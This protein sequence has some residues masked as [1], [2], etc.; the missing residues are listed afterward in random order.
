M[1]S[2]RKLKIIILQILFVYTLIL[3]PSHILFV[4]RLF[5]HNF[6]F[7]KGNPKSNYPAYSDNQFSDEIYKELFLMARKQKYSG[8]KSFL[9][10][11]PVAQKL[12]H[13]NVGGEYNTRF[14]IGENLNNSLW[15]FGGSTMWG[16][17][18]YDEAT[19]PSLYYKITGKEVF[20]FAEIAWNSRQS[21][22]QMISLFGD[23]NKPN[24]IIFFDGVNDIYHG[25]RI[26]NKN[27]PVHSREK[28]IASLINTQ[29][30][31]LLK[32]VIEPYQ[33]IYNKLFANQSISSS[34]DCNTN[35]RKSEKIAEHLVNNWYSAYLISRQSNI[36]F[37]AVLQPTIYTSGSN[38]EY[39]SE[40]SKINVENMKSNFDAVYP[41]IKNK[42]ELKCKYD[43]SFCD[44]FIDA[45]KFINKNDRLFLDECHLNKKGNE[46]II[47]KLISH[48][49]LI[50][51][52]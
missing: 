49:N 37:Y 28:L 51:F 44:S 36:K 33:L 18:T 2:F 42:I 21:L 50:E 52:Q 29:D 32:S 5:N 7:Y 25:C 45:T 13:I 43:Q 23:G 31:F 4:Y 48:I 35:L 10:W 16:Y 22:N 34:Y 47:K 3:L 8:Y 17:G 39:F 46:V 27:I 12:K 9:V 11:K 1:I 15:F 6:I 24:K 14:S 26:E 20:N 40:K 30:K 19:I 41:I 38:Y